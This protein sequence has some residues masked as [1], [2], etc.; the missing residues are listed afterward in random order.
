MSEYAADSSENSWDSPIE[1]IWKS[2]RRVIL[3]YDHVGIVHN[4]G[5]GIL[6]QR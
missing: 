3:G 4:D 1:N 2:G 6:W 5:L